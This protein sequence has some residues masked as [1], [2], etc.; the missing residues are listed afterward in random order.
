MNKN[1]KQEMADLVKSGK[2][3]KEAYEATK[4][5]TKAKTTKKKAAK[6]VTKKAKK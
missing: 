6:K 5:N 4:K 2:T 1:R 3:G